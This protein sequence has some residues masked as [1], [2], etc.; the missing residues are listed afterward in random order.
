[1]RHNRR[2]RYQTCCINSTAEKIQAMVDQAREIT[3]DTFRSYVSVSEVRATFPGYSY[4]REHHNPYTSEITCVPTI[5]RTTSVSAST[6]VCMMASHV[7]ISNIRISSISFRM[8][9]T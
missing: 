8:T 5:S 2:W 7:S 3:W 9:R 4:Q 6:G 1:M